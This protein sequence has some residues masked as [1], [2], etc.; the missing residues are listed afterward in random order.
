MLIDEATIV[1]CT[2][3]AVS[4]QTGDLIASLTFYEK[5]F[6][7]FLPD[8]SRLLDDR[9]SFRDALGDLNVILSACLNDVFLYAD[10][11]FTSEKI[12]KK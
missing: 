5:F 8:C 9:D 1:S 10:T 7:Y 2:T 3:N 4:R 6:I 12:M 11:N